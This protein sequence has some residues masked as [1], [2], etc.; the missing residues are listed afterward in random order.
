MCDLFKE[1]NRLYRITRSYHSLTFYIQHRLRTTL[2]EE[3]SK[4]PKKKG[5]NRLNEMKLIVA[6]TSA[7][8]I[9]GKKGET[10]KK[11]QEVN[12]SLISKYCLYF[13]TDTTILLL[14]IVSHGLSRAPGCTLR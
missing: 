9:I 13:T 8:K 4:S 5:F 6:D 2:S 12:H 3:K 14:Q 7:G 10:V 11:I 1:A